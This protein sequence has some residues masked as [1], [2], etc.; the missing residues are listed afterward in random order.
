M[1]DYALNE[2]NWDQDLGLLKQ[3]SLGLLKISVDMKTAEKT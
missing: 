2:Y 3:V 1:Y